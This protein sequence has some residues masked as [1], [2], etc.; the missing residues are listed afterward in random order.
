MNETNTANTAPQAGETCLCRETGR[1][2]RRM[3]QFGS[4]GARQHLRNSRVEFL[5]ALRTIIDERIAH[6][7]RT[8]QKGSNVT[9]E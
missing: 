2:M 5:K 9:V 4:E 7:S 1:R 8:E 6:L 3:L